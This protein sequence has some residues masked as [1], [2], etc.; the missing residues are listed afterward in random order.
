MN[1]ITIASRKG[2]VCKTT[3]AVNLAAALALEGQRVLLL[4]MDSQANASRILLD[5]EKPPAPTLAH[6]LVGGATIADALRPSNRPGVDVVP[7]SK[8][9]VGAQ[10]ALVDKPGRET[11]LRRAL[12]HVTSYDVVIIDTSPEEALGKVNAFVAATHILMPFDPDAMSV[13][14]MA[15]TTEALAELA[16]VELANPALLGCLQV[17]VDRRLDVTDEWRE[18]VRS[19]YGPLLFE[20][21]LRANSNFLLCAAWHRDIFKIEDKRPRRGCEDF[22]AIAAEVM[23]RL[24]SGAAQAAA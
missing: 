9:L 8:E 1:T 5:D 7:G 21:T 14:G 10:M 2:G 12:R 19:A 15:T 17:K 3:V 24:N 16:S 20:S 23:R 6:V 4:D 13:E 18:Q 11:V 22:K